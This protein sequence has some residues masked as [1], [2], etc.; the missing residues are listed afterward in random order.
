MLSARC[1]IRSWRPSCWMRSGGDLVREAG[2][3]SERMTVPRDRRVTPNRTHASSSTGESGLEPRSSRIDDS[4]AG[5]FGIQRESSSL[6]GVGDDA[7]PSEVL[8]DGAGDAGVNGTDATGGAGI[9]AAPDGLALPA[10]VDD[11][12]RYESSLGAYCD[13]SCRAQDLGSGPGAGSPGESVPGGTGTSGGV[14]VP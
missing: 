7:F 4:S 1:P 10:V 14:G 12:G 8:G 9:P 5:T 2:G 6:G 13:G 3:R 11:P